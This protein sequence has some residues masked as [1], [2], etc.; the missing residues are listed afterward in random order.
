MMWRPGGPR[1]R[2]PVSGRT[3]GALA[4]ARKDDAS[5]KVALVP[6]VVVVV[7]V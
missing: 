4:G 7:I 3:K 1:A 5:S 2:R 6:V